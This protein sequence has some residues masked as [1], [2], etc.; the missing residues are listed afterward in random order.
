MKQLGFTA[1]NFALYECLN[2]NYID[3][4]SAFSKVFGKEIKE[5]KKFFFLYLCSN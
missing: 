2:G 3:T 1:F 5:T 4:L